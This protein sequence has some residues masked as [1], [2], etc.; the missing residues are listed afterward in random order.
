M[1]SLFYVFGNCVTLGF[2]HSSFK[3]S[4]WAQGNSYRNC[5]FIYF[6]TFYRCYRLFCNFCMSAL[7]VNK[8]FQTGNNGHRLLAFNPVGKHCVTLHA[9]SVTAAHGAWQGRAFPGFCEKEGVLCWHANMACWPGMN[10][11]AHCVPDRKTQGRQG[12][13][14]FYP[15]NS[16]C[17]VLTA[18]H[19]LKLVYAVHFFTLCC[20]TSVGFSEPGEADVKIWVL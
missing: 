7:P 17:H 1:I 14:V 15:T 20:Q 8:T 11:L 5:F 3:A 19:V 6:L 4:P 18:W 13:P 2:G 16:L 10:W 12:K 9:P